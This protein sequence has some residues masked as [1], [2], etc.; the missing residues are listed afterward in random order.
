MPADGSRALRRA[1]L[2]ADPRPTRLQIEVPAR[3]SAELLATAP[4]EPSA[5]VRERVLAA[6]ARQRARG[7]LNARLPNAALSDRPRPLPGD[8]RHHPSQC[9]DEERV[10]AMRLA[11][12]LQYRAHESRIFAAGG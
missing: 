3:T 8:G 4:G 6:R 7:V 9:A 10:S 1:C 11:E 5:V 12:A 2:R